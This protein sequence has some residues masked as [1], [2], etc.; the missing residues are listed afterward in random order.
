MTYP[1]ISSSAPSAAEGFVSRV[2]GLVMS[3]LLAAMGLVFALCLLAW[4]LVMVVV[5]LVSGWITGRPSTVSVL[6]QRYRD[7]TRRV[8]R[9]RWAQRA[10]GPARDSTPGSPAKGTEVQDVQ[11]RDVNGPSA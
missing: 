10:S 9:P 5:S 11:W 3:L 7:L 8:S 6:W 2:L 1:P 4:L